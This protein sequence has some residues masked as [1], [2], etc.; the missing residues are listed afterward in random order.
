METLVPRERA[1]LSGRVLTWSR[2]LV[3][4][5]LSLLIA[6]TPAV[7]DPAPADEEIVVIGERPGPRLWRIETSVGGEVY[8]LGVLQPLPKGMVWKT[9]ALDA[10]VARANRALT[11]STDVSVGLGT[12]LSNQNAFRNPGGAR[13]SDQLS[14]DVRARFDEARRTYG[15]GDQAYEKWR[16]YLAGL[17]LVDKGIRKSGL[18]RDLDAEKITL[19]KIRSRR[20]PVE[21]V[22]KINAKPLI[23]ALNDLPLGADAAC[24]AAQLDALDAL[25]ELRQRAIAWSKGDIETLRALGDRDAGDICLASLQSGGAEVKNIRERLIEDWTIA[26]NASAQ[27][28]DVTFAIAP[29]GVLIAPDGIIERLRARGIVIDGP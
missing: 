22:G 13:V 21:V 29:M 9:T 16:P 8:I 17:V 19:K 1:R 14:P 3:L 24:L 26:L 20:I 7:A 15:L 12:L 5:A 27:R 23:N 18:S 28:A 10:A 11:S 25:P 4:L 2:R 6:A